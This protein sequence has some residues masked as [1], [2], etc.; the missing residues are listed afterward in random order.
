M[1][2]AVVQRQLIERLVVAY[3]NANDLLVKQGVLPTIELKDRVKAPVRVGG[4]RRAPVAT[5]PAAASQPGDTPQTSAY[6]DMGPGGGMGAQPQGYP[7][8]AG[9]AHGSPAPGPRSGGGFFG[10]RLGWG[11]SGSASSGATPFWRQS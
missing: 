10:G 4:D 3:K 5:P 1:V 8:G 9:G 7:Q 6:G 2:T 11:Q